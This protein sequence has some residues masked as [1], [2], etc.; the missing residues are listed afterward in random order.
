[1]ILMVTEEAVTVREYRFRLV[2]KCKNAVKVVFWGM[3]FEKF[4]GVGAQPPPQTLP[5]WPSKHTLPHRRLWQ[6]R[7]LEGCPH[8]PTTFFLIRP[9]ASMFMNT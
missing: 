6:R 9:L 7:G 4:S 3:K 2:Q 5:H 1:M 8:R